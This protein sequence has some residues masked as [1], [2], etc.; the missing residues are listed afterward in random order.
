MDKTLRCVG[1]CQDKNLD[2]SRPYLCLQWD[3]HTCI[4]VSRWVPVCGGKTSLLVQLFFF[5]F[6][7]SICLCSGLQKGG[8]GCGGKVSGPIPLQRSWRHPQCF[9]D[10]VW[11]GWSSLGPLSQG[12]EHKEALCRDLTMPQHF[13]LCKRRGPLLP[14]SPGGF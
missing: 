11:G 8:A 10:W 4:K 9:A 12:E 5:F 14:F 7:Q 3:I 2:F 1:V 6:G 13:W